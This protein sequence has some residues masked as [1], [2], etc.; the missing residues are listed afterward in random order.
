[1]AP[2]EAAEGSVA[3]CGA[4][5]HQGGGYQGHQTSG[6]SYEY[7]RGSRC[8]FAAVISVIRVAL[9][10][11]RLT[12]MRQIVFSPGKELS[13]TWRNPSPGRAVRAIGRPMRDVFVLALFSVRIEGSVSECRLCITCSHLR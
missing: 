11:E 4:A 8:L 12:R 9:Y 1:M 13:P 3:G 7:A 10:S 6:V 5:G 2:S